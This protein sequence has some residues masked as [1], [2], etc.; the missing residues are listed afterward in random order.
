MVKKFL[1]CC[2]VLLSFAIV[3]FAI[4]NLNVEKMPL[5]KNDP[6]AN[7]SYGASPIE[8]RDLNIRKWLAA[9]VKISVLELTWKVSSN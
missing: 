9:G 1:F 3:L 2:S 8:Q 7:L 6:Y 4:T 5:V